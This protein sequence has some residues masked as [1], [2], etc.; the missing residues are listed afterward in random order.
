MEPW[1]STTQCRSTASTRKRKR[2]LKPC[3]KNSRGWRTISAKTF[4]PSPKRIRNSGIS[5]MIWPALRGLITAMRCLLSTKLAAP[6]P[7]ADRTSL[8]YLERLMA[9]PKVSAQFKT[10][11]HTLLTAQARWS[12]E[13]RTLKIR[14]QVTMTELRRN[15]RRQRST[16][17]TSAEA[18]PPSSHSSPRLSKRWGRRRRSTRESRRRRRKSWGRWRR[19]S[20]RW[21][22]SCRRSSRSTPTSP[23]CRGRSVPSWMPPRRSS[24][25]CRRFRTR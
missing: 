23:R 14:S 22:R 17:P 21:T 24:K 4:L 10:T 16:S 8:T 6:L 13:P 15:C 25:Q 5:W 7:K 19:A 12:K 9:R 2:E 11:Y 1:R 18:S 3:Q 20:R